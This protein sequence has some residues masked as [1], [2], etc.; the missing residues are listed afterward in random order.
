MLLNLRTLIF[1]HSAQPQ[2]V[3]PTVMVTVEC[4]W[5]GRQIKR[6][7]TVN[8]LLSGRTLGEVVQILA[9]DAYSSQYRLLPAQYSLR[10]RNLS[11]QAF[12]VADT[13][14]QACIYLEGETQGVVRQL[15]IQVVPVCEQAVG[16]QQPGVSAPAA[17]DPE[18][19]EVEAPPAPEPAPKTPPAAAVSMH[20]QQ[21]QP[22]NGADS[23]PQAPPPA[24]V[25]PHGR[26]HD[27]DPALVL[28]TERSPAE[29]GKGHIRKSDLLREQL[30]PKI[31]ALDFSG[32]FVGNFGLRP[33][34]LAKTPR[35]SLISPGEANKY[36][37]QGNQHRREGQHQ[38]ASHCYRNLITHFPENED[39][40]LLLGKSEE[41]RGDY[42]QALHALENAARL[43]HAGAR[44]EIARIEQEHGLP[45]QGAQ[46]LVDL[47]RPSFPE[48][49]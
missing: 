26:R 10:V 43:G 12:R 45:A 34:T 20:P 33:E 16:E 6:V 44:D 37:M 4:P 25:V 19:S 22:D 15:R 42:R 13:E 27:D 46:N 31:E 9:R 17:A 35:V 41:D 47:W 7:G 39:Y 1:R 21:P 49:S 5:A 40:W 2:S 36:L 28:T 38:Q 32:L 30:Q 18:Q 48:Q 3:Q 8:A 14:V 24:P 23:L 29:K 11:D